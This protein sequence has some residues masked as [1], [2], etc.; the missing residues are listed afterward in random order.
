MTYLGA[1]P[2]ARLSNDFPSSRQRSFRHRHEMVR[3]LSG[4]D[5]IYGNSDIPVRAVFESDRA[6]QTRSEL[7]MHLAF[8]R[9]RADRP[10]CNQIAD[11]LRRNHV[12][13]FTSNGHSQLVQVA[14]Q[15][16]RNSESI[17]DAITAIELRVVDQTFPA[18]CGPRLFEVNS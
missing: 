3:R 2:A 6:R 18:D 9:A 4:A 14:Q 7:A 16:A 17:V 13:E 10:P 12:E 5:R 15:S 1:N 8:S 11:V